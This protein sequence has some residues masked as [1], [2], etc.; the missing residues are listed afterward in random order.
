[1]DGDEPC[2]R[3]ARN[4]G[5]CLK[6]YARWQAYGDPQARL[7]GKKSSPFPN[8]EM[9]EFCVKDD[10]NEPTRSLGLC[11]MHYMEQYHWGPHGAPQRFDD[12]PICRL[13]RYS[14][15]RGRGMCHR[16]AER[17]KTENVVHENGH[18]DR[19]T[20][21]KAGRVWHART[22]YA[23]KTHDW[24]A[25]GSAASFPNVATVTKVFGSW[26]KFICELDLPQA[27]HGNHQREYPITHTV[28]KCIEAGLDFI[29]KHNHIP[30]RP[31]W[32]AAKLSPSHE[33]IRQR[34]GSWSAFKL[35]LAEI[36]SE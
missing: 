16:C 14:I 35:A 5:W 10:C 4:R 20:C 29:D 9:P 18:W 11:N 32:A 17:S 22:G 21:L 2:P 15:R 6:H 7:I 34:F 24:R 25:V 12:C 13:R 33:A 28:D 23:P 30:S 36:T 3:P 19:G 1:M 27:P 26:K 31:E 8:G